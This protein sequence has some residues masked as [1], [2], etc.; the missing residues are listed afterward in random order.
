M[1]NFYS[2]AL[3]IAAASL[4]ACN[5][6]NDSVMEAKFYSMQTCLAS[7]E[8]NSKQSL[9]IVTDK[10]EE[11]SGILSNG[12]GFACQLKETGSSGTFIRGWYFI[13]DTAQ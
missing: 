8:K 10:P 1:K 5:S 2:I 7:I 4:T 12:K 3:T 13:S 6:S 11:V 9:K